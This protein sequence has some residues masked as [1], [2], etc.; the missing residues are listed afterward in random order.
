MKL[1]LSEKQY[2]NLLTV[3][4][5]IEL[6]EQA[7]PPAAEPEKGTSDKQAGGQGYPQVGKWESG[8]TRGPANQVGV[9]KWADVVGAKLTRSKGNQLKEQE[10]RQDVLNYVKNDSEQ[11]KLVKEKNKKEFDE[12]FTIVKIPPRNRFN[13]QSLVLPKSGRQQFWE[14]NEDRVQVFFK[15]WE[16]TV[17]QNK[18]PKN[19][20][21][22]LLF[23]TGTLRNF[24]TD[25]DNFYISRL[26]LKNGS[27]SFDWFINNKNGK[28]YDQKEFLKDMEIP[29][30]YK[31]D[32]YDKW[33]DVVLPLAGFLVFFVVP[34]WGGLVVATLLD[35]SVAAIEFSRGD[36]VGGLIG[37]VAAFLPAISET[38][39]W[40]KCTIEEAR[41]VSGYLKNVK[42]NDELL[43]MFKNPLSPKYI[44]NERHRYLLQKLVS[45]DPKALM[46]IIQKVVVGGVKTVSKKRSKMLKL[47]LNL[48]YMFKNNIIPRQA[49]GS[50]FKTL[51]AREMGYFLTTYGIIYTG[52]KG[53]SWAYN[54]F[55]NRGYDKVA[56]EK[57][58]DLTNDP[59]LIGSVG[60]D[61]EFE[62]GPKLTK[63]FEMG[64]VDQY[65]KK[66]N[67]VLGEYQQ[68]YEDTDRDRYVKIS[69]YLL[70]RFIKNQNQDFKKLA[71][72]FELKTK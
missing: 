51:G 44:K 26:T 30:E 3:I 69:I 9:T 7:E 23:P 14:P 48:N 67:P 56:Q 32:W 68:K 36:V 42:N 39:R 62:L 29:D 43:A 47:M 54:E 18:I 65:N 58:E 38:L 37:L 61:P 50:I 11:E 15:N 35:L 33:G 17:N 25:N 66:I 57:F 63:I 52:V 13:I 71:S 27:W 16:G 64:L 72:D 70:D 41:A 1:A 34:G 28:P 6:E 49:A 59:N 31:E 5:E 4:S 12:K 40:G 24:T 10:G 21:F 19:E 20:D 46:E 60:S 8:V 55:M 22:D 53:G 2:N 45:E